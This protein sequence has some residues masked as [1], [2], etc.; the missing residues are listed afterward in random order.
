MAI[1][2]GDG[3]GYLSPRMAASRRNAVRGGW[4]RARNT[5]SEQ[6]TAI[7]EKAGA[8]TLARYGR[9]FFRQIR[10]RSRGRSKQ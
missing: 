6:R 7:G 2:F 10:K 1:V 4:A 9:D 5:T 8:A 3:D